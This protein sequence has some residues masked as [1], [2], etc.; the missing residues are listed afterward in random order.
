MAKTPNGYQ[1]KKA[2]ARQ[3]AVDWQ[4]GFPEKS[5]SWEELF[6]AQAYFEK[7]G[8]RYGLLGEFRENCIC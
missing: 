8:R 7:L 4:L 5:W 2:A 6:L 1:Q 3:K